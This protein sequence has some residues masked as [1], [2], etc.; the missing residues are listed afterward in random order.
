MK[1]NAKL[2][3]FGAILASS[4]SMPIATLASCSE[5]QNNTFNTI[6]GEYDREYGVSEATYKALKQEFAL[7]LENKLRQNPETSS[8]ENVEFEID[9]LN[10]SFEFF[11]TQFHDSKKYSYTILTNALIEKASKQYDIKLNRI[12]SA[13]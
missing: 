12:T 6:G 7:Q 3:I 2:S 5:N 10:K 8:K 11:D 1:R 9:R 13:T 4:S